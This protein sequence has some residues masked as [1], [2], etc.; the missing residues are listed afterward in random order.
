MM[1]G[2]S[3]PVIVAPPRAND[4][5]QTIDAAFFAQNPDTREYTRKYVAG[6][7]PEPMPPNTWVHVMRRGVERV[8]GFAPPRDV[9]RSN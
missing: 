4:P 1:K 8:R 9:G 6:E 3:V 5:S 7:T 2:R